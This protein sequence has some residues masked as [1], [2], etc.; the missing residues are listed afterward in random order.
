MTTTQIIENENNANVNEAVKAEIKSVIKPIENPKWSEKP[1]F[2]TIPENLKDDIAKMYNRYETLLDEA[3]SRFFVSYSG[4]KSYIYRIPKNKNDELQSFSHNEFRNHY[5]HRTIP[6]VVDIKNGKLVTK[7]V[8]YFKEW[9]KHKNRKQYNLGIKFYP[10]QVSEQDAKNYYNSWRGFPIEGK[11]GNFPKIEYHLKHVWC[12]DNLDHYNF[13]M[14]WLADIVQNPAVKKGTALV[15]KGGK[16][17]GKSIIF[18]ELLNKIFGYTYIKIDKAEQITGKFNQHLQGK[19]F[20]V[21]EEAIWAGDKTAE[22]TLKSM[23]TDTQFI[24]EG[25]GTN[26]EKAEAFFRMAF[27]SNEKQAVPATTDER[28]FFALKVSDEYRDNKEYFD[29]LVAEIESGGAEAFMYHLQHLDINGINLRT[30]PRTEALFEDIRAKMETTERFLIDL[31]HEDSF[32]LQHQG[33]F[34][35]LW[36][37]K[38]KKESLYKCFVDWEKD[39]MSKNTYFPKHDITSQTK[40]VR[41]INKIMSFENTKV[42]GKNAYILPSKEAARKMFESKVKSIV[43]WLDDESDSMVDEDYELMNKEMDEIIGEDM[44]Q[45]KRELEE[46]AAL[47]KSDKPLDQ[48]F[49]K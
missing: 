49:A 13:L 2:E 15:V 23:I 22:G 19:L 45:R 14:A 9:M 25:K 10:G 24:I 17:S 41:E 46:Q 34:V 28:R 29:E 7:E 20:V 35:P 37:S 27:I 26:A 18:G 31:L 39:I 8:A 3:N 1:P 30:A 48:F 38:V 12:R 44:K 36:G 47:A 5:G 33:G 32:Q 4:G 6:V 43:S 16:G 40:L 21:L 11:E 42:D